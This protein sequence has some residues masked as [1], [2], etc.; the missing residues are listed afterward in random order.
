[1]R[2]CCTSHN[3]ADFQDARNKSHAEKSDTS[4]VLQKQFDTSWNC[5]T[6]I[7]A[8]RKIDTSK[9]LHNTSRLYSD[10][11]QTLLRH[12]IQSSELIELICGYV[13]KFGQVRAETAQRCHD[14]LGIHQAQVQH[15]LKERHRLVQR[16]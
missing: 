10:F 2:R 4:N 1:M 8:E 15:H 13:A 7:I 3:I 16:R 5:D 12:V 14:A 11:M 9:L 6:S